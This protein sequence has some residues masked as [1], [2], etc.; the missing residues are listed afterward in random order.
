MEKFADEFTLIQVFQES[1]VS[2]AM[3]VPGKDA[4]VAIA[5]GLE[6]RAQSK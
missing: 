5:T 2:D 1:G 3:V 6:V 4:G